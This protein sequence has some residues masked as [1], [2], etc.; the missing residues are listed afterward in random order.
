MPWWVFLII[1]AAVIG[2]TLFFLYRKGKKMQAEQAEQME[3]MEAAKQTVS[4]LVIDKKK[5]T[6]K[7]AGFPQVVLD[8]LPRLAK[9]RKFPVVKGKVGPKIMT[10][11]TE[12]SVYEQIPLKK[13]IKA[14]VSGLY[15][16]G[17]RGIRG[18]LE[19]KGKKK[20]GKLES[21]LEKGRGEA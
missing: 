9:G 2:L 21:L 17:V 1:V 14:D 10:F 11:I 16:V 8:S 12:K 13:E 3:Q 20:K 7:A 19:S 6:L 18:N 15:I 4:L 5:S